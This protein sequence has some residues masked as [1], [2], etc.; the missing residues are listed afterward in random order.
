MA[1]LPISIKTWQIR[2][3][4]RSAGWPAAGLALALLA[5]LIAASGS[6]LVVTAFV[7]FTVGIALLNYPAALLYLTAL[8]CMVFVG[9]A[10]IFL[11]FPQA[12]WAASAMVT[13]LMLAT[14][15]RKPVAKRSGSGIGKTA[16][17]MFL[18]TGAGIYFTSIF[19]STLLNMPGIGQTIVGIR[20]YV[21][22]LGVFLVLAFARVSPIVVMRVAVILFGVAAIQWIYCL[23]Q[24]YF[25]VPK[26][27]L[28]L[29]R[30]SGDA[31]S[32]VGSFGGNPLGGGYTGEMAA[33]LA[34]MVVGAAILTIKDV[35]PRKATVAIAASFVVSVALAETKIVF[36]LL[37][38]TL[39]AILYRF[40]GGVDS[41]IVRPAIWAAALFI[42]FGFVYWLKYW[43]DQG[44]FIH[45]FT[46][47]FDPDFM[48]DDQQRGRL[49]SLIYW[50]ESIPLA[51]NIPATLLGFGPAAST[52]DSTIAGAGNAVERYGL[53]LDNNG[54]TK[55]LWD[56]GIIGLTGVVTMIVGAYFTLLKLTHLDTLDWATR[57]TLV[58]TK[59]MIASFLVMLPYQVSVFGGAPMQF[60]FWFALGLVAY[61]ANWDLGTT[62]T[63]HGLKGAR[64]TCD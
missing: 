41:S 46:Y 57:W 51:G 53:G 13:G 25:I 29:G 33:F 28:V 1:S 62:A 61:A 60:L 47:S 45:A 64:P 12:N 35:I 20:N 48:I 27:H 19:A 26:R 14:L 50:W 40:P 2:R 21:P 24:Q 30:I 6:V 15:F 58:A 31:E 56:F 59:G 37:P 52:G 34:V 9:T 5:G 43:K 36:L 55:I 49:G 17:Y 16:P 39:A 23:A 10:E 11:S 22:F 7:A 4:A 38:L 63:T 18:M 8:T 32:I 3:L 44:D 54:V 42:L